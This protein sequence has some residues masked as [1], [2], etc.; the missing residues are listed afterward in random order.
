M[1]IA[2]GST[3][4][5]NR[6]TESVDDVTSRDVRAPRA[7]ALDE[8]GHHPGEQTPGGHHLQLLLQTIPAGRAGRSRPDHG[9]RPRIHGLQIQV[10]PGQTPRMT[11][12]SEK[13]PQAGPKLEHKLGLQARIRAIKTRGP[14]TYAMRR[15][16]H[17]LRRCPRLRRGERSTDPAAVTGVRRL[18]HRLEDPDI[19][20][21]VPGTTGYH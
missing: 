5:S 2:T 19:H 20:R 10:T 13:G 15:R 3:T 14:E 6:T 12:V 21:V 7:H 17:E 8:T 16:A 18:R 4:G 11:L 9:H 1:N